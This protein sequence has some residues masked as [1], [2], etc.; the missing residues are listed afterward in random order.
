MAVSDDGS[1]LYALLPNEDAVWQVDLNARRPVRTIHLPLPGQGYGPLDLAIRP[2][3]PETVVVSH[4]YYPAASPFQRLL[5]FD[6]G[7]LRT[8]WLGYNVD[9]A[10]GALE[11]PTNE[12]EFLDADHLVGLNN[13]STACDRQIIDL[14]ASG[15]APAS[16]RQL[17]NADCFRERLQVAGE[18]VYMSGGSELDPASL[19]NI[20]AGGGTH[21]IS[22]GFGVYHPGLRSFIRTNP[23]GRDGIKSSDPRLIIHIEQ[24]DGSRRHLVRHAKTDVPSPPPTGNA[25]LDTTVLEAVAT[26]GS[27]VVM[28]VLEEGSGTVTVI[29]KSLAEI[30]PLPSYEFSARRVQADGAAG[31]AVRMPTRL[32][33]YDMEA[34]RLVVGLPPDIGPSGNSLAIVRPGDGVVERI[35]PLPGEPRQLAISKTGRRAYVAAGFRLLEVDLAGGRVVRSIVMNAQSITV[36]E[37]DPQHIAVVELGDDWSVRLWTLKNLEPV[38]RPYDDLDIRALTW[39]SWLQTNGAGELLVFDE[40]TTSAPT[41]RMAWDANGLGA[42]ELILPLL[43]SA[44]GL[45]NTVRSG[46]YATPEHVVD[47]G[48]QTAVGNLP[49]LYSSFEVRLQN[50]ELALSCTNDGNDAPHAVGVT[51]FA[52]GVA[53]DEVTWVEK[54]RLRIVDSMLD[55]LGMSEVRACIP[56]GINRVAVAVRDG[57]TPVGHLYLLDRTGHH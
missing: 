25:N 43:V 36:K 50:A 5:A 45:R 29:S 32:I 10:P 14:T 21:D 31:L 56:T 23:Y 11:A 3:H 41:L 54:D 48:S 27:T 47:I 33:E 26:G 15:L 24:Y 9:G 18:H 13:E 1:M 46:R 20:G 52:P 19:R 39:V 49:N 53:P 57:D 4:G 35:I 37:D 6:A 38:G 34:D 30:P 44:D 16:R 7:V 8:D 42:P 17:L 28:S 40:Y 22:N 2:G 12:I 55:V 51:W